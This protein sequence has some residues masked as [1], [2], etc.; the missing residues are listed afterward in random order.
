[1]KLRRNSVTGKIKTFKELDNII[2]IKQIT[3]DKNGKDMEINSICTK[4]QF[5][6]VYKSICEKISNG[7]NKSCSFSKF[8]TSKTKKTVNDIT[9]IYDEYAE[10]LE[11]SE[12]REEMIDLYRSD[13]I[14]TY[15]DENKVYKDFFEINKE[16]I[17][18]AKNFKDDFNKIIDILKKEK[19]IEG[20]SFKIN[21]EQDNGKINFKVTQFKN[22]EKIR[23]YD[24]GIKNINIKVKNN[25]KYSYE[26]QDEIK[27]YLS[28]DTGK[29]KCFMKDSTGLIDNLSMFLTTEDYVN[30]FSFEKTPDFKEQIYKKIDVVKQINDKLSVNLGEISKNEMWDETM[31]DIIANAIEDASLETNF[32]RKDYFYDLILDKTG[33]YF[34]NRIINKDRIDFYMIERFEDDDRKIIDNLILEDFEF[35]STGKIIKFDKN[36]DIYELYAKEN[37]EFDEEKYKEVL[38][39]YLR[40]QFDEVYSELSDEMLNLKPNEFKELKETYL[41]LETGTIKKQKEF[42]ENAFAIALKEDLPNLWKENVD[43]TKLNE[44]KIDIITYTSQYINSNNDFKEK[45]KGKLS[46]YDLSVRSFNKLIDN[47][48]PNEYDFFVERNFDKYFSDELNIE[49]TKSNEKTKVK[50]KEIEIN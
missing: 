21:M 25:F 44:E 38:R 15:I 27:S 18:N 2:H 3:S 50:E 7:E 34:E 33:E 4:E 29:T 45:L 13:K 36:E 5:N 11:K 24:R 42:I 31:S 8:D 32:K 20:L 37:G 43:G 19:K 1:M 49:K 30:T 10:M 9:K 16:K 39:E 41:N 14:Q 22:N 28:I 40:G 46:D 26:M 12:E 6:E 47:F 48:N 35:S 17:D 23:E